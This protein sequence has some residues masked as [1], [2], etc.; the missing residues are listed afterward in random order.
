MSP[1]G[2]RS[3]RQ[4]GWHL[5]RETRGARQ[6]PHDFPLPRSPSASAPGFVLVGGVRDRC[7]RPP[8]CEAARCRRNSLRHC[9]FH[10]DPLVSIGAGGPSAVGGTGAHG[11]AARDID[12]PCPRRTR[13]RGR[14]CPSGPY[15]P[16]RGV[17]G[18]AASRGARSGTPPH[19]PRRL[20]IRS[21]RRHRRILLSSTASVRAPDVLEAPASLVD[22]QRL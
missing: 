22:R 21:W 17:T 9:R 10:P 15:P 20:R 19:P 1:R 16:T 5:P 2:C 14:G 12:A 18:L 8:H 3:V 13:P 6:S 7:R 11:R 4:M